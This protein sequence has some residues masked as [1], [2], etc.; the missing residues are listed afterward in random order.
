MRTSLMPIAILLLT[1]LLTGCA[2]RDTISSN[3][4][5]IDIGEFTPAEGIDEVNYSLHGEAVKR[6]LSQFEGLSAEDAASQSFE[7]GN[8]FFIFVAG[9]S[10]YAPG[11]FKFGAG[12]IFKQ[13]DWILLPTDDTPV[14]EEVEIFQT[15]NSFAY[16]FNEVMLSHLLQA[17]LI[18]I[19]EIEYKV[20]ENAAIRIN[21]PSGDI[22]S[23]RDREGTR[24]VL[25]AGGPENLDVWRGKIE[26]LRTEKLQSFKPNQTGDD[27]SE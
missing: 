8:Y 17:N 20:V 14:G 3:S 10:V 7:K 25:W 18:S 1:F 16:E 22:A 27:N 6:A 13:F 23:L 2:S 12:L 5:K 4:E 9:Y 24:R 21:Y 26:I 15:A 19:F 11:N